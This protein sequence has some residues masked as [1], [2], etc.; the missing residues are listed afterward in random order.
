MTRFLQDILRQPDELMKTLA[1]LNSHKRNSLESAADAIRKARHI[2]VTG[3]GASWNAAVGAGLIFHAGGVPVHMLEA[4]ELLQFVVIP[5]GSVILALSRSGRSIEIVKLLAKAR[6]AGATVVG[7]T[8]PVVLPVPPDNGISVST[9]STLA[10]GAAA[11]ATA[12]VGSFDT[13]LVASLTSIVAETASRIPSWQKQLTDTVWLQPGA[14]YYFLARGSSIA[15]AFEAALLWEE[16]VK[17]PATAMGTGP[18]RHGPQEAMR[19]GVHVAIW[20]DRGQMREPDLAVARDLAYIGCSVLL[21]GHDLPEDAGDLVIQLPPSPP[22]WQFITDIFPLQLAANQLA[23]LSGEDCDSF[24][25]A[26]Y[27]VQGEDGLV[28]NGTATPTRAKSS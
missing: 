12:S 22:H 19:K 20:V 27:I 25:F 17:S 14:A 7:V 9:Y 6:S 2:Y 4:S 15:S 1:L 24:R 11:I 8:I 21:I 28:L 18:F 5:Q 3:I 16:G 26:S 13:Q 23:Q 10:I